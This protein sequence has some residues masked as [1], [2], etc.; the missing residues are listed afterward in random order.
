[1]KIHYFAKAKK[2]FVTYMLFNSYGTVEIRWFHW[3]ST[4]L[5]WWY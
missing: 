4:A 1:V 5:D 3:G 2:Q